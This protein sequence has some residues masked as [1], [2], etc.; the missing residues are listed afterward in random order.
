MITTKKLSET[1]IMETPHKVDVRNLY[2][3]DNGMFTII[4]LKSGEALK[5]HI[6][7]VDVIFYVLQGS[8]YVLIGEEKIEVSEGTLVESPKN[9]AH[10]WYNEGENELR[11][12]V[13]KFSKS[14][15]PTAFL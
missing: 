8:G 10:C 1:A 6:T 9:I 3:T 13:V 14:E 15:K 5:K 4:T 2:N 12:I 11:F 7:P